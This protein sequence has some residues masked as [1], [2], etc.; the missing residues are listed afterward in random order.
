MRPR[1]PY[2]V[3][4]PSLRDEA[5]DWAILHDYALICPPHRDALLREHGYTF[6]G[7]AA[8]WDRRPTFEE[9]GILRTT[10]LRDGWIGLLSVRGFLDAVEP[11]MRELVDRF[12]RH[13]DPQRIAALGLTYL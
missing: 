9:R 4:V 11:E 3:A 8:I 7:F 10:K 12:A 2:F 1:S 6:P 5:P 13:Y